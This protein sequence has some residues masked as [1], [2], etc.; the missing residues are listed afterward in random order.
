MELMSENETTPALQDGPAH[1]RNAAELSRTARATLEQ[2]GQPMSFDSP[3]EITA[4]AATAQ[5]LAGI[6]QAEAGIATALVFATLAASDA[7]ELAEGWLELLD[8]TGEIRMAMEE[9]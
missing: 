7:D 3:E 9:G 6:A 4:R 5:A 2:A 1:L 8:P